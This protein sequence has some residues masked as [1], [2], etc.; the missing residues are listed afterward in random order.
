MESRFFDISMSGISKDPASFDPPPAPFGAETSAHEAFAHLAPYYDVIT[1]FH[2]SAHLPSA[3]A[4]RARGG[5]V[6]RFPCL[7]SV[8]RVKREYDKRLAMLFYARVCLLVLYLEWG[9]LTCVWNYN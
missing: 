8:S 3:C 4:L 7:T 9:Y 2:K 6:G 5:W 1:K